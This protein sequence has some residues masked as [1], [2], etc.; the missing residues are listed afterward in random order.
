MA[1]EALSA[2]SRETG[3]EAT[4][5]VAELKTVTPGQFKA[6][7]TYTELVAAL[8]K[9]A[10]DTTKPEA[11]GVAFKKLK[12]ALTSNLDVVPGT[13]AAAINAMSVDQLEDLYREDVAD[14]LEHHPDRTLGLAEALK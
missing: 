1:D 9:A 7:Q 2:L 14:F 13:N 10:R 3:A 6:S 4:A 11:A 5:A 8:F 12:S